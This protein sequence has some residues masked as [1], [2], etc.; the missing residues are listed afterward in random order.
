[1]QVFAFKN[2]F[3]PVYKVEQKMDLPPYSSTSVNVAAINKWKSTQNDLS[4]NSL[5]FTGELLNLTQQRVGYQSTVVPDRLWKMDLKS[6]G[7]IRIK[8][9]K[10]MSDLEYRVVIEASAVAPLVWI[11]VQE[12]DLLAY[13][14]DNAFTMT[15]KTRELTLTLTK[16]YARDLTVDDLYACSLKSCYV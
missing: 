6:T 2:A 15:V 4:L 12:D 14:D 11:E 3:D 10:K 1:V 16:K 13:F 9:F 7:D 5:V 8:S